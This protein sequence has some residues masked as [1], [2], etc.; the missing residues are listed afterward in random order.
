M[1]NNFVEAANE[2]K[3]TCERVYR[4][5]A[6]EQI[7][8]QTEPD[9]YSKFV[10][11]HE[12]PPISP[13]SF[14]LIGLQSDNKL[15]FANKDINSKEF[16]YSY[17]VRSTLLDTKEINM[18][19]IPFAKTLV[20][21]FNSLVNGDDKIEHSSYDEFAKKLIKNFRYIVNFTN[22][23]RRLTIKSSSINQ[24]KVYKSDYSAKVDYNCVS[25]VVSDYSNLSKL[26]DLM[27]STNASA[28]LD[29]FIKPITLDHSGGSSLMKTMTFKTATNP[30]NNER[31]YNF[32]DLN[33]L[34]INPSAL[35][36]DIPLTNI[37]N[38]SY[39]FE[40]M[41][42]RFLPTNEFTSNLIYKMT[43]D[44]FRTHL[45]YNSTSGAVSMFNGLDSNI[46]G[47]P[48]FLSDQLFNKVLLGSIN[49][50]SGTTFRKLSAAVPVSASVTNDTLN[51]QVSKLYFKSTGSSAKQI[52]YVV[53]DADKKHKIESVDLAD[54]V[55]DEEV[56]RRFNTV[57][58]RNMIFITNLFRIIRFKLESDLVDRKKILQPTHNL[59]DVNNTE[60][61]LNDQFS[62]R[63]YQND[64]INNLP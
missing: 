29:D 59:V 10:S 13:V 28:S 56:T 14:N 39:T 48:K 19:V 32:I 17:G 50:K 36:R 61:R 7:Y 54:D 49:D 37:F 41:L 53:Y 63:D 64:V 22:F 3:E 31:R 45:P 60:F 21:E 44:P 2:I 34:P 30:R 16:K 33:V 8:L 18:S 58:V 4:E 57:I 12:R 26:F 47:R 27:L 62:N 46:F 51:L 6:D 40:K 23:R 52:R 9:Q 35:M 42:K 38:Y 25:P 11:R 20:H 5:V 15:L 24:L 1:L 55:S 43:I